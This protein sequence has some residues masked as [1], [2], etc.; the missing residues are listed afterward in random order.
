M[1]F[2]M[3]NFDPVGI[4][5]D[6]MRVGKKHI[7]IDPSTELSTGETIKDIVEF[8]QM[9][10]KREELIVRCIIKK[11][12]TYAT[13]RLMEATDRGDIDKLYKKASANDSKFRDL[14]KMLVQS[15]IFLNK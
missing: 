1:G 5:R 8:K 14:I 10:K 9:L 12:L 11:M 15:D 4:W 2:A 13:G 3:E 7:A 6:R